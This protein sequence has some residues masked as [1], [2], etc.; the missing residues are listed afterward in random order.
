MVTLSAALLFFATSGLMIEIWYR[1]E[2]ASGY[3]IG[4]GIFAF[5]N[6][7]VYF[8]DFGLTTSFKYG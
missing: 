2:N 8:V 7:I 5:L 3:L 4:S 6:G 1:A